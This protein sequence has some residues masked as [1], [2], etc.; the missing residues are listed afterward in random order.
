MILQ[1]LPKIVWDYNHRTPLGLRRKLVQRI[2]SSNLI[3]FSHCWVIE[4]R[5]QK[6]IQTALQT[7]TARGGAVFG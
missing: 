3:T 5:H 4:D 6:V 7:Q 2:Q 1:P